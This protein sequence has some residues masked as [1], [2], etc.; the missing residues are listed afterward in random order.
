MDRVQRAAARRLKREIGELTTVVRHCFATKHWLP[1]LILLYST[2]DIVASLDRPESKDDMTREDFIS[3]VDEYMRPS[4]RL[5]CSAID[6]YAARCGLLHT[7]APGSKLSR[8]GKA[9]EVYY[10]WGTGTVANLEEMAK[11]VKWDIPACTIHV[12][13]LVKVF[14]NGFQE[15]RRAI[16]ADP[17]RAARVYTRAAKLFGRLSTEEVSKALNSGAGGPT[18]YR[19]L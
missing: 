13:R 17:Q 9:K 8:R 2:M 1:G 7:Y 18:S 4:T 3:W 14:E 10:A 12:D 15:F 5:Q 19:G 16:G 6:L 11:R